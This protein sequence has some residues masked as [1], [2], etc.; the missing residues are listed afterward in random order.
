MIVNNPLKIQRTKEAKSG[1]TDSPVVEINEQVKQ[2]YAIA[3]QYLQEKTNCSMSCSISELGIEF[4]DSDW[5]VKLV[6]K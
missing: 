1:S 4:S 5:V 3:T 6:F 2:E